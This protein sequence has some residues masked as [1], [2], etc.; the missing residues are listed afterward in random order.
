MYA[1]KNSKEMESVSMSEKAERFLKEKPH[2]F[3]SWGTAIIAG[4][5]LLFLLLWILFP[6][7]FNCILSYGNY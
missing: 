4:I 1:E 7:Y 6:T 3:I 2:W 5:I